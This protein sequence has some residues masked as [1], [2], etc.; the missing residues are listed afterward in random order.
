MALSSRGRRQRCRARG[1]AE[2][3]VPV[4]SAGRVSRDGLAGPRS[5]WPF[6]RPQLIS[7]PHQPR[8]R[9]RFSMSSQH[10]AFSV[11]LTVASLVGMKWHLVVVL[12]G[13]PWWLK[14]DHL[15]TCSS[16]IGA[17]P[18]EKCLLKPSGEG[19]VVFVTELQEFFACSG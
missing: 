7:R 2:A 13:V 19:R 8:A 12:T 3:R 6:A 4:P 15:F 14:T 17:S 18:L 9:A 1:R 11:F 5:R 16:A 10:V